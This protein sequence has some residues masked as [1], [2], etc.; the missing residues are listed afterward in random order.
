MNNK[1][2]INYSPIIFVI[3]YLALSGVANVAMIFFRHLEM[4]LY[5]G[6][7][8]EPVHGGMFFLTSDAIGYLVLPLE[9]IWFTLIPNIYHNK[10]SFAFFL[11]VDALLIYIIGM[12]YR[13]AMERS[14]QI[15]AQPG[16]PADAATTRP[17]R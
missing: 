14:Q 11:I 5:Y 6:T 13:K 2:R 3:A 10:I 9:R 8:K 15:N 4:F 17:H 16:N 12:G 1:S 7:W